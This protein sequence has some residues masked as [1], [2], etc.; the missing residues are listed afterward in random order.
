MPAPGPGKA[1]CGAQRPHQPKGV[2]CRRVAGHGTDHLGTGRCSRHGGSTPS[3]VL[4]A[5]EQQA[6]DACKTLGVQIQSSPAESLLDALWET[7]GAV[8]FYR[9]LVQDLAP[10]PVPPTIEEVRGGAQDGQRVLVA[11]PDA[12]YAPTFHANGRPTGRSAPHILVQ[13]WT[14]AMTREAD[15]AAKALHAGVEQRMLDIADREARRLA[16]GFIAF[17]RAMGQDP[18]DASVRSAMRAALK[19]ARGATA[20]STATVLEP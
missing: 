15:I 20:D 17:A 10:R 1:L 12:I 8:A 5:R 14:E 13:L 19:V 4:S 6:R 18:H 9:A 3:H 7:K 2:L 11:G 16:D